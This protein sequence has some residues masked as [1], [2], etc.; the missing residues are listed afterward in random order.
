MAEVGFIVALLMLAWTVML[1]VITVSVLLID[2]GLTKT[3]GHVERT[4]FHAR[5]AAD[6]LEWMVA[7]ARRKSRAPE[8]PLR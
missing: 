6:A 4:E 8:R 2:W 5:R 3:K 7:N 1:F